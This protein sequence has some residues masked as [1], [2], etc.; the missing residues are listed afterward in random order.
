MTEQREKPHSHWVKKLQKKGWGEAKIRRWIEEKEQVK[1]RR[2]DE[3]EAYLRSSP[4]PVKRWIE[5]LT[6]LI[7]C[8]YTLKV[9]LLVH[10]YHSSVDTEKIDLAAKETVR[11][12][13]LTPELL[14]KMKKDVLYEFCR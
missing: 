2:E 8:G 6:S 3:D 7:E 5:F 14:M 9:G 4:S 11:I 12:A 10:T 13:D 1:Q